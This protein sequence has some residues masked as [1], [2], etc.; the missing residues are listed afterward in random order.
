MLNQNKIFISI[1]IHIQLFQ[2]SKKLWSLK[3]NN[4]AKTKHEI[5]RIMEVEFLN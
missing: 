2:C 3:K 4:D 5:L 1:A